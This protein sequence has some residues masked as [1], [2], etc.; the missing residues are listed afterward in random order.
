VVEARLIKPLG[1]CG[2]RIAPMTRIPEIA[3]TPDGPTVEGASAE[4][5]SEL[6]GEYQREAERHV[7]LFEMPAGLAESDVRGALQYVGLACP[8]ELVVLFGWHNGS[9]PNSSRPSPF[10][11]I[12]PVPLRYTS[13]QECI[14]AYQGWRENDAESLEAGFSGGAGPDWLPLA[15]GFATIAVRCANDQGAPLVK[16]TSAD[17]S[18]HQVRSL[19]TLIAWQ[20]QGMASGAYSADENGVWEADFSKFTRLQRE[21]LVY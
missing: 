16:S 3:M 2:A 4:L 21:S 14:T 18:A 8:D 12:P 10:D 7:G 11:R 9:A 5:L 15:G 6:L 13:L 1:M 17:A 19:C 20:I